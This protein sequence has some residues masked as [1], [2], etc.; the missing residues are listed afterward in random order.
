MLLVSVRE[1]PDIIILLCLPFL[2]FLKKT[3]GLFLIFEL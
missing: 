3:D 2:N 1:E